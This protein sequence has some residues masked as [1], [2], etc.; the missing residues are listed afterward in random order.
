MYDL[1]ELVAPLLELCREA[2]ERICGHYHAPGA[3][4]FQAKGDDTPLT[5]ADLDSH[6]CLKAGLEALTPA[7][8]ILS[9]ESEASE[10]E[11]RRDWPEF[12]MVDPLDGTKEFLARTGEFTPP[13]NTLTARSHQLA[14]L[15]TRS[16]P[17]AA[18]RA[19]GK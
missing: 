6:A 11:G 3:D 10:L 15:M 2:G 13:G 9:E 4:E 12:W 18:H 8:P 1:P 17:S 16:S 5:R 19:R 14:L 7:L